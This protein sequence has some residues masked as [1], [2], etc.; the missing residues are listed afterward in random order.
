MTQLTIE[1]RE[2]GQGQ[3]VVVVAG[4]VDMAT[5]PVL[6]RALLSYRDCGV[7]VDLSAVGF[8]D[9]SGLTVLVQ[10]YTRLQQAGHTLRTTGEREIVLTVMRI[11]GLL[12]ILHGSLPEDPAASRDG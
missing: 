9:S 12:N 2:A 10:A 8:L 7:L 5:A 4:E 1:V 11:A 3:V 6:E